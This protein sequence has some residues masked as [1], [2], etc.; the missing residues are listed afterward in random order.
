MPLIWL[1]LLDQPD[2]DFVSTFQK[3]K[4]E[5]TVEDVYDLLEV[6]EVKRYKNYEE[7]MRDKDANR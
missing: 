1:H 5:L 6:L 4:Y 7:Q 3:L 2:V